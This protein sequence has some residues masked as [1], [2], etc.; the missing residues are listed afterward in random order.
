M[1]NIKLVTAPA[2]IDAIRRM[3]AHD[4]CFPLDYFPSKPGTLYWIVFDA[5][6]PC[7]F[8]IARADK[9]DS[10]VLYLSRC[11]VLRRARGKRLQRRLVRTRLSYARKHGFSLA[12]TDVCW[13]LPQSINNL[14]ECGFRAYTPAYPWADGK[15]VYLWK[16]LK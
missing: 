9:Y 16:K 7:G 1:F 4:D 14:I 8:A 11:G 2:A 6:G 13:F 12:V 5:F 10:R 15:S 3:H